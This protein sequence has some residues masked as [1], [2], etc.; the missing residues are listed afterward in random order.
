MKR[1]IRDSIVGL[2]IIGA[3]TGLTSTMLWLRGIK[4]GAESWKVEAT[5]ENASGLAERSP[6][7]YRGILVGSIGKIN[8]TPQSVNASIEINKSDLV[9]P[10]PVFAKI[11]TSSLLGG[12]VQVALI[13]NNKI[14]SKNLEL[15]KSKNCQNKII[16]C[17]GDKIKGISLKNISTLTEEIAD[18]LKSADQENMVSS[19]VESTKQFDKTQ[20]HLDELINQV[21]KELSGLD[22]IINNL[23]DSSDHIKSILGSINNPET[24][25]DIKKTASSTRSITNKIDLMSND[26]AKIIDDEDLMNALRRVTI[27]LGELFNEIYPATK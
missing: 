27:G 13:S 14:L 25:E 8:I 20:K 15:P 2:S 9:L 22:P 5:F 26:F 16:L 24:L 7:T 18:L 11:I 19:L 4:L 1:S 10:K 3:I 23:K 6:V 17:K 21:K 12:D